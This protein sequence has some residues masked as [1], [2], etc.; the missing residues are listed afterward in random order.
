MFFASAKWMALHS[1]PYSANLL[2]RVQTGERDK[3]YTRKSKG[4]FYE[5]YDEI[6]KR[7][8]YIHSQASKSNMQHTNGAI[9]AVQKHWRFY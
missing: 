7:K 9:K 2:P 6:D 5:V 1:G 8:G 4:C 3:R